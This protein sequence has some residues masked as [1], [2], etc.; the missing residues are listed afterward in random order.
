MV[1]A[2]P[3]AL[4]RKGIHAG[5]SN[6]TQDKDEGSVQQ[7]LSKCTEAVVYPRDNTTL[8]D[9]LAELSHHPNSLKP[10]KKLL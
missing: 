4:R 10:S 6:P 7:K 1:C 9:M 5:R 3:H 2:V 8:R